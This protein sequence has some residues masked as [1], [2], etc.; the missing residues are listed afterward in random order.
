MYIRNTNTLMDDAT[1]IISIT[2]Q[3]E[4]GYRR[5]G[6][7]SKKFRDKTPYE[8]TGV[9]DAGACG[10]LQYMGNHVSLLNSKRLAILTALKSRATLH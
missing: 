10:A 6:K 8:P 9:V 2:T 1:R 7:K 4:Q 3:A 5:W